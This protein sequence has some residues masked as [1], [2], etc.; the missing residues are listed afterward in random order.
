MLQCS[1]SL[2]LQ[3]RSHDR[4]ADFFGVEMVFVVTS[5]SNKSSSLIFVS[6]NNRICIYCACKITKLTILSSQGSAVTRLRCGGQCNTK[7]CCKFIAK[8]NSE[9]NLKIG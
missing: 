7:F 8:F 1:S 6:K 3:E 4:F 9:K 2:T 5:I